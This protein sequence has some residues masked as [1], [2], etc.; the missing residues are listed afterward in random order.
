MWELFGGRM[1][2]EDRGDPLVTWRREL[3]EEIG[4]E[5]A[6]ELMQAVD[7]YVNEYGFRRMVFFT[8]WPELQVDFD[9]TEGVGFAWFPVGEAMRLPDISP[10]ARRDV[11]TFA[12]KMGL[13]A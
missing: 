13:G 5:L 8:E 11:T 4:I 2:E 3:R 12:R 10:L 6:P 7:D 9:L 1:D